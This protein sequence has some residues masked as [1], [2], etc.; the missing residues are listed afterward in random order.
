MVAHWQIVRI[1]QMIGIRFDH[2]A[3]DVLAE[4]VQRHRLVVPGDTDGGVFTGGI[5]GRSRL[6]C[7]AI[8]VAA[9]R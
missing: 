2:H 8:L 7:D 4:V 1:E 5:P 6:K 3:G 9:I